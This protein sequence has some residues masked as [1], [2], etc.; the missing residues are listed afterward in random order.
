[1]KRSRLVAT[2]I[3]ASLWKVGKWKVSEITQA[4]KRPDYS[5]E[6]SRYVIENS[7]E[8]ILTEEG[9]R[10]LRSTLGKLSESEKMEIVEMLIEARN[11]FGPPSLERVLQVLGCDKELL[12]QVMELVAKAL[13]KV[14]S[15]QKQQ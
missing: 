2:L 14:T 9:I 1:M 12:G 6:A 3:I 7:N 11:T 10:Y 5:R 15:S 4:F 13:E 8:L